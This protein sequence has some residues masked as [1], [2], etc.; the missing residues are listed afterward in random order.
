MKYEEIINTAKP[1]IGKLPGG[2]EPDFNIRLNGNDKDY[3]GVWQKR[4]IAE[5]NPNI[6][7][8]LDRQ[9]HVFNDILED[10]E[11]DFIVESFMKSPN[12]ENVSVQ[13]RKDIPDDRVGSIRTTAWCPQFAQE[14]WKRKFEMMMFPYV[15]CSNSTPTDWWQGNDKRL[16]WQPIGLSPMMR[17]MK[18]QKDGQHYAHYDAG[19]I[20]PNDNYRTLYSMV[21]YLTT[22]EEGGAT[23]FIEDGQDGKN[24][25]DRIHDDWTREART[26]EVIFS[27][28]AIKGNVLIFP[29]RL[30]HD[31]EKYLGD[32]PRIIIRTDI[33]FEAI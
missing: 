9:I 19:F 7:S 1:D 27:S 17:F 24:T 14:L 10:W 2:W 4:T 6:V 20:Y 3:E 25:W 13:G 29:H 15:V 32:S 16:I 30:C 8:L 21:I 23:R 11:C 22:N 12:F 31:V 18:Y 5:S 33:L 28:K 26:D